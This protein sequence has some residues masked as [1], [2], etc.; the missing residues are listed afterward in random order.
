MPKQ[1]LIAD[2]DLL[3]SALVREALERAGYQVAVVGDGLEA[4][5]KIQEGAPDFL[6]L[7]L[8]MPRLDGARLCRHL[9]A[10]PRFRSLPVI[11]LTGTPISGDSDMEAL[12]A[13]A[14]VAKRASGAMVEDLLGTLRA[15][16]RGERPARAPK[17][18]RSDGD[19]AR[20]LAHVPLTEAPAP[21][22]RA[23]AETPPHRGGPA[24]ATRPRAT[25]GARSSAPR[26]GDPGRGGRV[27]GAGPH[28]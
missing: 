20:R 13:E 27:A 26:P 12:G 3:L 17:D 1:I 9:K 28:R 10:D 6:I 19:R 18:H 24:R 7:D 5:S 15:L 22:A 8:V 14:Y 23:C 25:G 21:A 11:V 2:N 4:W 16:E